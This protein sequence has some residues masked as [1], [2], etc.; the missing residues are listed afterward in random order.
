MAKAVAALLLAVLLAIPFAVSARSAT[1]IVDETALQKLLE[2]KFP[3][4]KIPIG[5]QDDCNNPYIERVRITIDQG[6]VHVA[7]HFTGR[8]GKKD[9][10]FGKCIL[11]GDPSDFSVSGMPVASGSVLKLSGINLDSIEKSELKAA[12]SYLL[13]QFVGDA[14]QI[15]LKPAAQSALK[16]SA[17]Y[18]VT[19]D[20]LLLQTI[21]AQDK[22][23]TVDF[24]FKLSVQ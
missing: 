16:G 18:Q 8:V 3:S 14:V 23:L 4:G 22:V 20:N 11:V 6:R 24:D 13:T 19:L 5:D 15:D 17:P 9:P 1:L 12:I 7:G 21:T 2:A 10:L